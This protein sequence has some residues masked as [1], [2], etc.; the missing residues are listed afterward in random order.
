M[1]TQGDSIT[2]LTTA[3]TA[4]YLAVSESWLRQRRMSGNLGGQRPAPPFLR[5]GRAIR[6]TKSDLDLWLATQTQR[7][8]VEDL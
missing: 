5:L 2:C 4:A 8:T 1:A 7:S 6:Y 3:E